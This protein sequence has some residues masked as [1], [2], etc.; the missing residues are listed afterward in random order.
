MTQT[1]NKTVQI[2][3][4]K[5]GRN[6]SP[7]PTRMEFDGQ[8]YQ[9]VDAGLRLTVRRS[10]AISQILTLSDGLRE[11]RLRSDNHG[12]IWTLLSISA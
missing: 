4:M 8:T 10:G 6:V 11:F 3:A 9:F 12:G 5:F 2:T 7:Y 1:I